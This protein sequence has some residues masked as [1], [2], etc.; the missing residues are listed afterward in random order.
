MTF[1]VNACLMAMQ[2]ILPKDISIQV[3]IQWYCAYNAP[4]SSNGQSE[5]THFIKVL[6]GLMG[7]NMSQIM[8]SNDVRDSVKL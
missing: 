5:W 8:L 7:Y 2:H 6:L 3:F 1:A 4:G